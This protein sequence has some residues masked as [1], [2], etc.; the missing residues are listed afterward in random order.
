MSARSL[1]FVIPGDLQA[2]TGG[3]AYD[4]RV[5]AGLGALGWRVTVQRLDPSFPQPSA[6]ALEHAQRV[7]TGLPD[8]AVVLI[9]GLA[10]GAMPELLHAQAAR[11]R[12]LAL[13]HHPVAAESGLTLDLAGRLAHSERRALQAMRHVIVTSVA[14][15]QA[16]QAYGVDPQSVSVVEPGTDPAPSARALRGATLR[17]LCVA[18]VIPRKGHELLLEALAPLASSPWHLTCVGSLTRSPATVARLRAQLSRLGLT[19]QVTITG[20]VDSASLAQLYS[21]ADLF[22]LPTLLEGYGMAVAEAL[23]HGVPVISTNVGAI[24]QLVG[25]EAGVLVTP[26][27]TQSLRAALARVMNEPALLGRLAAGAAAA[28][29]ALPDWRQACERMSKV[30]DGA[31]APAG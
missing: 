15:R 4:R 24:A 21:Q 3:Y 9:D 2:A 20:E 8:Q 12:L 23:A 1:E 10:A 18:T 11:L 22:V 5:I 25:S 17:L 16:L 31:T 6:A 28:G 30:L 26:G 19:R 27:D 7:F 13:V 29:S 14:T